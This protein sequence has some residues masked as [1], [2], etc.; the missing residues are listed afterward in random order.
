[1]L[2]DNGQAIAL[3]GCTN[4][5]LFQEAFTENFSIIMANFLSKG[6]LDLLETGNNPIGTRNA[7]LWDFLDIIKN[8][9]SNGMSGVQRDAMVTIIK[10]DYEACN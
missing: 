2:N 8:T 10:R 5:Y 9:I 3:N 7:F 6:I 4:F 1:M